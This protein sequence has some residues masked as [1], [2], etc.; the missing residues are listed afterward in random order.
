MNEFEKALAN[1]LGTERLARIQQVKI[2]IA[3]VGGLGSNCAQFL[4]RSGFTKLRLVDFD[5]VEYSNLNRQ[6]Y[7]SSQVGEK[8]V[9]VLKKN[10][11]DINPEAEIEIID[12]QI[13]SGNA[14]SLF[15]DCD[16]VAEALDTPEDKKMLVEKIVSSGKLVVAVSGLAG[17][18]KP[19]AIVTRRIK[20]NF[21][22]IGDLFSEV[23]LKCPAVA[24]RVSIAAAKQADVILSYFVT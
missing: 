20:E 10:L 17:W 4:I 3:G 2:G 6:F 24:S 12:L 16:A 23:T 13:N 21:Y 14:L 15:Q 9:A 22:L 8:K 19:D 7:F 5:V 1:I 11:L 18:G